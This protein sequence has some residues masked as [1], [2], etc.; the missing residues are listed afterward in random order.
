MSTSHVHV[1][2]KVKP[3]AAEG[4]GVVGDYFPFSDFFHDAPQPLFKGV[5]F[6]ADMVDAMC[7][8][9]EERV[10]RAQCNDYQRWFWGNFLVDIFFM[11]DIAVNYRTGYV[12]EGHFVNDDWLAAKV[13]ADIAGAARW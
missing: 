4:G 10:L 8:V 2:A 13:R 12:H 9:G 1:P 11:C 7:G 5:A 3:M 6:E